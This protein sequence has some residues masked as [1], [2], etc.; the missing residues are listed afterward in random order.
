MVSPTSTYL[1][2]ESHPAVT[3]RREFQ[4]ILTQSLRELF[5]ELEPHSCLTSVL[6]TRSNQALVECLEDS[7]PSVRAALTLCTPPAYLQD[8][9]FRF[10]VVQIAT[11]RKDVLW[12][13]QKDKD[14]LS[15]NASLR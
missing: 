1:L 8:S 12:G 2:V 14:V 4:T 15:P 3:D 7:V 5:G 6:E 10:D 9:A 11:D 13:T